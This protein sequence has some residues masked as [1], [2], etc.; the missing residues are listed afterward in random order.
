MKTVGP[1]DFYEVKRMNQISDLEWGYASDFYL[2]LLGPVPFAVY[3]MLY[4][5]ESANNGNASTHDKLFRKA[6]VS[7]G[8]FYHALECLE[9]LALVKTYV[10]DEGGLHYFV[11]ALYAPKQP[12][13]FFKDVLLVG[14]LKKYIGEDAVKNL[15]EKYKAPKVLPVFKDV[16]TTFSAVY[17]PDFSDPVY[18]TNP[19]DS[20]VVG[21]ELAINTD[22][23]LP[24]FLANL[25]NYGIKGESLNSDEKASIAKYGILYSIT[26]KAMAEIIA[27]RYD[28]NAKYG[29][30]VD[31]KKVESDCLDTMEFKYLRGEREDSQVGGDSAL[32]A[33]IRMMDKTSPIKFLGILQGNTTP[34]ASDASIALHLSKDLK[35]PNGAVNALIDYALQ[36]NDNILSRAFCEKIAAGML[37]EGVKNARDAMD[38]LNGLRKKRNGIKK[39]KQ[40]AKMAYEDTQTNVSEEKPVE[41]EEEAEEDFDTLRAKFYN[42]K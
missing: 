18:G 28:G 14:T 26:P 40:S 16:S 30:R 27:N 39:N 22:F 9:A 5:D 6:Q 4:D 20:D 12:K 11:Y 41:Q 23:N 25:A 24:A 7:S 31:F 38:Y 3:R 10:N 13:S 29:E 33:K 42:Q 17:H 2:P 32:A 37:R 36:T 21:G 35:L 19:S 8:E 15:R 1:K 34:I